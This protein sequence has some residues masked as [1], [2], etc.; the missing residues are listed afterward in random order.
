[1]A[2]AP[3][4]YNLQKVACPLFLIDGVFKIDYHKTYNDA[5]NNRPQHYLKE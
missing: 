4:P 1:M 5:E 3:T 2:Y